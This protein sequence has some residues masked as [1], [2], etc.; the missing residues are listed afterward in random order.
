MSLDVLDSL[1][2]I[3][4]DPITRQLSAFF[5]D[6][7]EK[8]RAGLKT[9]FSTLLAGVVRKSIDP[10]GAQEVYRAV[11]SE[12]VDPSLQGRLASIVSNRANLDPA[13]AK[14]ESA[15]GSL[16]GHNAGGITHAIAEVSGVKPSSATSLLAMA[17]PMLFSVL[18]RHVAE[19]GLGASGLGSLLL[20]QRGSL[21]RAG[22]DGRITSA[23]GFGS[24]QSMLGSTTDDTRPAAAQT[25]SN[26]P[27]YSTSI[28]V[29]R[30]ERRR[31]PWAAVAGIAALALA[32]VVGTHFWSRPR[33]QAALSSLP[34]S[35]YFDTGQ[36]ELNVDGRRVIAEVA[37]SVKGSDKPIA[38]TG[39]ADPSGDPDQNL[40]LAKNRAT[41][42]RD[43]LVQEGVAPSRLA[44]TSVT[45]AGSAENARRV[46]ITLAEADPQAL[47]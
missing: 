6:S 15:V 32:I 40:A 1:T 23:L 36:S 35:V 16:F 34:A 4:G 29:T 22:L 13:L 27:A 8:T 14:G 30:E 33:A 9:S 10:G 25:G 41:A 20:S 5:G 42:V 18:K 24:L 43:A 11:T 31:I 7:E 17:A 28:P 37:S 12:G 45:D 38:V 19:Q 44:P 39:H 47:R 46:E 21:Q 26:R 2:S 3:F